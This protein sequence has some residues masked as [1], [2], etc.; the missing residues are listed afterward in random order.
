MVFQ[1]LSSVYNKNASSRDKEPSI[2]FSLYNLLDSG[3]KT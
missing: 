3:E 1:V 2:F